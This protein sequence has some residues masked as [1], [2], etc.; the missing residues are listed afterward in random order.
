MAAPITHIALTNKIFAKYFKDKAKKDFFIGTLFPDIR[1]LAAI[2][3]EKTHYQGLALKDLEQDSAFLAGLKF[4]SILDIACKKFLVEKG[5]YLLYPEAKHIISSLKMLEDEIFYDRVTD[6][7]EYIGYLQEV[8][9]EE[10]ELGVDKGVAKRWH[11]ILQKYLASKPGVESA[12]NF[13]HDINMP[14][15]MVA[16]INHDVP[17]IRDDKRI[18]NILEDLYKYFD[19]LI[20]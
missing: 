7:A 12:S 18:I 19:S 13:M 3:R 5:A 16:E 6:W 9:D 15:E 8:L 20:V 1:Y 2:D 17:K 10:S 4:H 14:D 11:E